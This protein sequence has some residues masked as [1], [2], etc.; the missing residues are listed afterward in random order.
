MVKINKNIFE[1]VTAVNV[2]HAQKNIHTD[3]TTQYIQKKTW[4]SKLQ[5]T[6]TMLQINAINVDAKYFYQI[7][8]MIP[9]IENAQLGGVID[10]WYLS[11]VVL[12]VFTPIVPLISRAN[13]KAV[14][15][16][17]KN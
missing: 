7:L 1:I 10:K 8:N 2:P 9:H 4:L 6:D 11:L 12:P 3:I 13:I 14:I 5:E 17:L 16:I 15:E